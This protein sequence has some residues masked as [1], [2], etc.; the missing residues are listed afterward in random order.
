MRISLMIAV[1]IGSLGVVAIAA[2]VFGLSFERAALLAPA[3]VLCV[4]AAVALVVIW[5]KAAL[6]PWRRRRAPSDT[7]RSV[8]RPDDLDDRTLRAGRRS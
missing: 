2:L 7:P 6:E 1:A 5:T 3:I 8:S 4:G